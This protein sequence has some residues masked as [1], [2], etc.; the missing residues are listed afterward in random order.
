VSVRLG[1]LAILGE[2]NCYGYQLRTE[3][4]RRT[5]SRGPVNVGQIYNTLDRLE[6]DKLVRK[7]GPDGEAKSNYYEITDAGQREVDTWLRTPEPDPVE[8]ASKVALAVTLQGG[9]ASDII[10][11]QRDFTSERL[12]GI[13]ATDSPSTA[14]QLTTAIVVNSQRWGLEAELRALDAAESMIDAAAAAGL[15]VLPLNTDVPKRGRPPKAE[16]PETYL[17]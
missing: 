9:R 14:E 2:G 1:L 12:R 3:L 7:A 6:R 16:Q 17:A 4:D 8:L 11:L 10:H 5:G 15:G 13:R